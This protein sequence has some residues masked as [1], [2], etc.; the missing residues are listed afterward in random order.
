M[1]VTDGCGQ[2]DI[3]DLSFIALVIKMMIQHTFDWPAVCTLIPV[4]ASQMHQQYLDSKPK[5]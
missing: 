4:I 3:V 2:L 5:P 1:H